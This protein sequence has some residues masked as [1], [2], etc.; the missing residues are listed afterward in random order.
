MQKQ[1]Q[2][3]I[4]LLIKTLKENFDDFHGLYLYGSFV[5]GSNQKDDD[6]EVVAIFDVENKTKREIIWPIV[7]KIET[8]MNVYIDL[9]P[10]T[11]EEFKKDEEFYNEVVNNGIFFGDK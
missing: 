7:G 10:I 8:E 2:D 11:M 9:H 1:V 3:T 5:D 6:M 4:N